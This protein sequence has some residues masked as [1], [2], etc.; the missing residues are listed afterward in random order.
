MKPW[1]P[2]QIRGLLKRRNL[3]Q[4]QLAELCR[5]SKGA[6]SQWVSDNQPQAPSPMACLVLDLIDAGKVEISD[7]PPGR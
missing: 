2:P 6:V 3:N 4:K 5:V 1:T 7:D